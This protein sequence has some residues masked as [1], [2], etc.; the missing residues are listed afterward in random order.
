MKFI[1]GRVHFRYCI[2]FLGT[3]WV[4]W[5]WFFCAKTLKPNLKRKWKHYSLPIC[6]TVCCPAWKLETL[7]SQ[8]H[9]FCSFCLC[10]AEYYT[11]LHYMWYIIF[12]N[13]NTNSPYYLPLLPTSQTVQ[14]TFWLKKKRRKVLSEAQ[15]NIFKLLI[16]SRS[17]RFSLYGHIRRTKAANPEQR[18]CNKIMFGTEWLIYGSFFTAGI[19]SCHS[20]KIMC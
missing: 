2:F 14:L 7:F 13:T 20:R 17:Q 11:T 10:R 12:N 3:V 15:R 4:L 5:Q 9:C 16:L 8:L 6:F 1:K 18:S 19:L